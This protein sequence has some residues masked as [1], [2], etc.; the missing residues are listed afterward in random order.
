M[1]YLIFR[2]PK[3][4]DGPSPTVGRFELIAIE[5]DRELALS[6]IHKAQE[7]DRIF[8]ES[9]TAAMFGKFADFTA[10]Y[11]LVEVPGFEIF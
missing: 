9:P 7:A 3:M 4:T 1:K 6:T 5:P 2:V 11:V 8:R 10:H